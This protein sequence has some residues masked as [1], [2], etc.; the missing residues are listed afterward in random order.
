MVSVSALR[1]YGLIRSLWKGLIDK[2]ALQACCL[3]P[4]AFLPVTAYN[5]TK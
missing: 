5:K 1:R 3:L 2:L 4:L